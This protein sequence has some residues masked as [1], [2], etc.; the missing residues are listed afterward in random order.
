MRP[1]YRLVTVVPVRILQDRNGEFR[2]A[3][4]SVCYADERWEV[5]RRRG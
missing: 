3:A 1:P 2:G 4:D 5:S